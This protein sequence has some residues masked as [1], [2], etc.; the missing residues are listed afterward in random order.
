MDRRGDRVRRQAG[1]LPQQ[2]AV[3]ERR[4]AHPVGGGGDDLRLPAVLDHQR[5]GPEVPSSRGCATA[6]ARSSR[7]GRPGTTRPRGP[8]SRPGG[9]RAVPAR[10]LAEAELHRHV[11]EVL[12]PERPAVHVQRVEA[13]RAEEREHDARRPSPRTRSPTCRS[14]ASPRAAAPRAR[15]RFHSTFPSCATDREDRELLR[16]LRHDVARRRRRR[17]G[18]SRRA[19]GAAGRAG[20]R[21]DV[22]APVGSGAGGADGGGGGDGAAPAGSGTGRGGGSPSPEPASAR[23]SARPSAR[24]CGR[25]RRPGSTSPLPGIATFQRTFFVSLHSSGGVACGA[26][27]VMSGPRHCG[28]KLSALPA[29]ALRAR[30]R[31]TRARQQATP[32]KATRDSAR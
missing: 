10:A 18:T 8:T 22:G 19:P 6:H 14:G 32:G 13:A 5:G 20:G 29:A 1:R 16:V 25:P 2:I 28:Q 24:R 26:T 7:R 23:P 30:R 15:T 11:P 9:P 27:P 21:A 17:P 12:L 3:L 4:S 31:E